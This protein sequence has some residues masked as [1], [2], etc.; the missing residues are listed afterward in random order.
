MTTKKDLLDVADFIIEQENLLPIR[1]QFK[2]IK[3]AGR[4][5]YHTR[6]ITIPMWI[7]KDRYSDEYRYWYIIHEVCHFVVGPGN[8]HNHRFKEKERFWLKEFGILVEYAKAYPKRLMTLT[9]KTVHRKKTRSELMREVQEEYDKQLSIA[10]YMKQCL[11]EWYDG[12]NIYTEEEYQEILRKE[13]EM[14]RGM[15]KM[16]REIEG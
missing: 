3:G 13:E 16:I 8:S 9:G 12:A 1:I 2:E 4:A 10:S 5:H 11:S 7:W 15:R 14:I 6:S